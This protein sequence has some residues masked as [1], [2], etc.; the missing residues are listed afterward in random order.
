M[1][2]SICALLVEDNPG[3]ARLIE[4]HFAS[5]AVDVTLSRADTI[6]SAIAFLKQ[7][8]TDVILADLYLPDSAGLDTLERLHRECPDIPTIVLTGVLDDSL[9]SR[10]LDRGAHDCLFK[11]RVDTETIVRCLRGAIAIRQ[12]AIAGPSYLSDLI[13]R[14]REEYA[15]MPGLRLTVRQAMRLWNIDGSTCQQVLDALVDAGFLQTA[16]GYYVRARVQ[17]R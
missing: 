13:A 14:C 2:S 11:G 4:E 1:N 16:D 10:A 17:A 12:S 9:V 5:A 15:E 8:H 6:T 7:H 3:D